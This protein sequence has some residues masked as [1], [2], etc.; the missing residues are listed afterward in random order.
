[1][2]RRSRQRLLRTYWIC[3]QAPLRCPPMKAH[4]VTS[5]ILGRGSCTCRDSKPIQQRLSID[6]FSCH[7]TDRIQNKSYILLNFMGK[8]GVCGHGAISPTT[9]ISLL[10]RQL[11]TTSL[12]YVVD[13]EIL[14][15]F[16]NHFYRARLSE[17]QGLIARKSG[18]IEGR[19]VIAQLNCTRTLSRQIP[20]GEAKSKP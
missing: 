7:H 9:Y 18:K 11:A 3:C 14:T 16:N 12:C 8:F 4:D 15:P 1:M 19:E 17:I 20:E 5:L 6:C 2:T 13:I 10:I